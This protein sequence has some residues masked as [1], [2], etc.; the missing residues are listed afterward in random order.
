M[1]LH[2]CKG[3]YRF[4]EKLALYAIVQFLTFSNKQRDLCSLTMSL[5]MV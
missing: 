1:M 3:V 5:I 2:H 4:P